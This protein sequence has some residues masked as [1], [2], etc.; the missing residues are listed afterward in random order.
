MERL[1]CCRTKRSRQDEICREIEK[2]L[3]RELHNAEKEFKV[4]LLGKCYANFHNELLS[5]LCYL[6]ILPL[7]DE[8]QLMS[9]YISKL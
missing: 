5:N 3:K 7:I 8:V 9:I 4:L 1:L 6:T 2:R